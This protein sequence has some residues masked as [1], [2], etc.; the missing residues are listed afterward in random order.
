[1][2]IFRP[3]IWKI[4]AVFVGAFI[5][6]I[7]PIAIGIL[8][9]FSGPPPYLLHE[10]R[11]GPEWSQPAPHAFPDGTSVTVH[12]YAD[13]AAARQGASAVLKPVPR[14]STEYQPGLTRY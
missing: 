6:M 8:L 4:V 11:I 5:A 10:D 2:D 14:D 9:A 7:V 3:K 1:M 13:E 12:A